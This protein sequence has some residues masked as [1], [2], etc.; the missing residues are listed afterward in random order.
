MRHSYRLLLIYL[1]LFYVSSYEY[2]QVHN[3]SV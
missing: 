3:M 2:F 1:M